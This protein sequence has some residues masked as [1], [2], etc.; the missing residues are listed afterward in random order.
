MVLFPG[1]GSPKCSERRPLSSAPIAAPIT[2]FAEEDPTGRMQ[3]RT[4]LMS[5]RNRSLMRELVTTDFK[6]RYQGSAIGYGWTLVRPLV[7]FIILYI[8]FDKFLKL[9]AGVP[10]YPVYLL[11]GLVMW[12]FFGDMTT[13]SLGC[14]IVRG[15]ILSKMSIPRWIIVV[16][17][18]FAIVINLFFN[19][20][21]L[22]IFL[23]LSHVSVSWEI[24]FL[25]LFFLEVYLVGLG[26]SFYLAAAFVKYRD[27]RYMWEVMSLALFYLTPI[28]YPLSRISNPTLQKILLLNPLAQAIQDARYVAVTTDASTIRSEYGHHLPGL[29]PLA[30]TLLVLIVGSWYFRRESRSFAENL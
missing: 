21:V 9:G 5:K 24:L 23:I 22:A 13:Q 28:I 15:D 3:P 20:I 26:V 8:V 7:T 12:N 4:H 16:S 30:I 11:L 19:L 29:I 6:L 14:I 18:T 1:P 27:I 25:P 17:T 2:E 10:H